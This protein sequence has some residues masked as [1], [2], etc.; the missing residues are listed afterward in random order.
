MPQQITSLQIVGPLIG[1]AREIAHEA[2]RRV[3]PNAALCE[4][5][6]VTSALAQ[7]PAAGGEL[8]VLIDPPPE[9]IAAALAAR[10][11][12]DHAR[13]PVIVTRGAPPAQLPAA[14]FV[15][16][17]V[18]NWTVPL[19][20]QTLAS[21]ASLLSCQRD[22]RRLRGDLRTVG[23]RL[24]HDL[25]TP[26]NCVSTASEALT[27]PG[28]DPESTT[29]FAHSIMDGVT[30]AAALVDRLSVVMMATAN[31]VELRLIGMEELVWGTLQRLESEIA[32]AGATVDRP[33]TW[34]AVNGVPALVD[35]IWA[36]LIANSLKHAGAA[37]RITLGWERMAGEH[38][39]WVRDSGEG[40]APAKR[41]TLFHPFERLN[42]I[43]A[44]RGYGL[45]IVRRLV[46]L[47]GG[48]CGHEVDPSPGGSFY[49]T[50]RTATSA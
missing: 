12:G 4:H 22:N 45:P 19:L 5:R 18:E 7:P 16:V 10:D 49:F 34:P 2:I 6:D 48:R 44:P 46:E 42:E 25:R 43:S 15:N 33:E 14:E 32:R 35:L 20:A 17:A 37:P 38:C 8:L 47:Q 3:L 1:E 26:L 23:R 30:E 21:A 39:F 28:G 11:P 41:G 13:W 29:M 50:L 31:P 24:A 9:Q 40:V 27:E 36:N